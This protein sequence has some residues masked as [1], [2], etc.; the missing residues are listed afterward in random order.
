[1]RN[2]W[3]LVYPDDDKIFLSRHHWAAR[4]EY[5]LMKKG[6]TSYKDSGFLNYLKMCRLEK[7]HFSLEATNVQ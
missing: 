6:A 4:L 1:M 3:Y 5:F 7:Y 2:G